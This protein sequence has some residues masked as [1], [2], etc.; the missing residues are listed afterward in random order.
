MVRQLPQS[1]APASDIHRFWEQTGN[2]YARGMGNDNLADPF[3][4]LSV[5]PASTS[6]FRDMSGIRF[7]HPQWIP[8]NC[9]ACGDCY[10]VCPDTALPGLVS[11]AQSVF[12]QVVSRL[13]S[14]GHKL[15]QLPRAVRQLEPALR[16]LMNEAEE[17]AS[18]SELLQQA[19]DQTR[20]NS[21]L[22]DADSEELRNE[23]QL[24]QDELGEFQ[25]ALS[26]PYYTLPERDKPGSG[27]LF[28]LTVDP[29]RCKGCMECIAVCGDDALVTVSQTEESVK[30][31]RKNW[32]FWL[33]LPT[34]P[35]RYLR[36]DDLEQAAG[37][38]HTM[39]LDKQ[40]YLHLSSGDGACLGCT[41]KT[42]L[43]LFT[44]TV[45]SLMR[46][47]VEKHIAHLSDLIE[48]LEAKLQAELT[49]EVDADDTQVL[50]LILD[51]HKEGELTLSEVASEIEQHKGSQPVDTERLSELNHLV[52][53]LKAL[54]EKYTGGI[55]GRGRSS[56]GF[57]NATGC[58][59]VWGST[60][61]FNP[62]PF[63]W[64]NHLFQ[65]SASMAMGVFEGHMVKMAAGF[66]SIRRAEMEL[67][68]HQPN[69]LEQELLA[70]LNWRD[71]TDDEL[72]LCPPVV[73]VGGD[74][75]MYDIG[76][77]NLSRAMMSGKPL[78]ILVL[79]TQVYSNTGGQACTSGFLGQVSDMAAFGRA[80]HG[81]Q[82]A[83]KEIGL[84]GMAHRNTYV[85]QSTIAHA[86]HM[87][88]GFIQ[89]L[90][91]QRP[92]L[93]NLYCACQP[94]H[95]IGDDMGFQQAKLAVE[96][97]AYPLFRFDPDAG[98]TPME[99][100]D[101]EGN[102]DTELLWPSYPLKYLE[103]GREQTMDLSMTFADFAMTEGRFRKHFRTAP[104]D[105]WHDDMILLADYLELAQDQR[106][107]KVPYIWTVDRKHKLARLVMNQTMVQSCE[108]RRD[109]WI[110]LRALAGETRGETGGKNGWGD[111]WRD[112]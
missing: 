88:E 8:E 73:V 47:R 42:V 32:D 3:M 82:E 25:F 72:H 38:L 14:Q 28:S 61:P 12:D 22:N 75:A 108:D 15:T 103:A 106:E 84:I 6:L 31:L 52:A 37:A 95:G 85:M 71:F 30:Q 86:S 63:P 70:R 4:A 64:A 50:Q 110:M 67:S 17:T 57:L 39:L 11:D 18:V 53:D 27:G 20:E 65:D 10:T 35:S 56:M 43:H 45:E 44:A 66:R 34:T 2:F 91:T 21:G 24:F 77:Q 54:K 80:S 23:F 48:R 16:T 40:S 78:K 81:K 102:P 29:Y 1:L 55:T 19:I 62:Y 99:C 79:D 46:P 36:I 109:F 100:F 69:Q 97:R 93:F 90:M 112:W 51:S 105:T 13:Q 76:F 104:P 7:H 98:N 111:W 87:I 94:E 9:T 68:D 58:S 92:A 60:F 59:S 41:E 89:G 49:G 33:D 5:M 96:S 101:L 83:R 107:Y 74:G 26:R